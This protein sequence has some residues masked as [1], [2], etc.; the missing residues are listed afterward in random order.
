MIKQK[1]I[2]MKNQLIILCALTLFLGD[3]AL[4]QGNWVSGD[5]S[6]SGAVVS[7]SATQSVSGSY[8][9]LSNVSYQNDK[10]MATLT[11]ALPPSLD[12]QSGTPSLVYA[13]SS[14]PVQGVSFTS[15]KRSWTCH[16]APGTTFT[17]GTKLTF[18]IHNMEI[19]DDQAY[20]NQLASHFISFLS[21]P[22][23][24]QHLD[25]SATAQFETTINSPLPVTLL[26]FTA[27]LRD[28][29]VNAQVDLAWQTSME[30]NSD[31]FIVERSS[32]AVDWSELTSVA[33]QG[34]SSV[35]V[36]Y[37]T[38]DAQPLAGRSYYRLKQVDMDNGF[39]Y[40]AVRT[41]NN[42]LSSTIKVFPNPT[43]DILHVQYTTDKVSEMELKLTGMDGRVVKS[44]QHFSRVGTNIA[45]MTT[46]ELANG[47]YELTVYENSK[48]INTSKVQKK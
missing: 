46:S 42:I 41:V 36:D 17:S 32:N 2:I 7:S 14:T 33:A 5:E 27:T 43:T 30:L 38:V 26:D 23:N 31:R 18:S 40:S 45:E 21:S 16:F 10:H 25:N 12:V 8:T 4:A 28:E 1:S 11:Y 35:R 44:I 3:S 13:S 22:A 48:L 6:V 15:S 39:T 34:N 37:E 20:S 19:K 47:M 29:G 9:W 24:D